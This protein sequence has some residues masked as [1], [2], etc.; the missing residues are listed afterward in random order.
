MRRMR[1][2][3]AKLTMIDYTDEAQIGLEAGV[4]PE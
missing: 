4:P 2:T 3:D 1:H